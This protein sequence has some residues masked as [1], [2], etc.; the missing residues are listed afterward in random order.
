MAIVNLNGPTGVIA[1]ADQFYIGNGSDM[2]VAMIGLML[3]S[4][5]PFSGSISV[6]S[7]ISTPYT[8]TNNPAPT[9]VPIL[10]E[11]RYLNGAISTDGLLATA[12]TGTSLII[13]PCTAQQIVL[14]CTSF[15]SGKMLV[16]KVPVAGAT[17]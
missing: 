3:V 9:P 4:S 13:I 2:T 10:Y 16:Y 15:V 6:K 7:L 11:S 14:D 8:N 1:S 5:G 12:I 17:A